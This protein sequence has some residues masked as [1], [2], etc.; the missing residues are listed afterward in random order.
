[1]TKRHI[2]CFGR[3]D[4]LVADF[5]TAMRFPVSFVWRHIMAMRHGD[6]PPRRSGTRHMQRRDVAESTMRMSPDFQPVLLE[7]NAAGIGNTE[8][9]NVRR[10]DNTGPMEQALRHH[11]I[12]IARQQNDGHACRGE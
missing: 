1:V 7:Q 10:A 11:R 3:S 6:L 5:P 2:M 4:I 9:V 8:H 12:M